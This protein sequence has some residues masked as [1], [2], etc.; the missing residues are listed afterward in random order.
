M[1]RWLRRHIPSMFHRRLVLL[2][3]SAMIVVIILTM[4][5]VSLSVGQAHARRLADAE[6]K[7]RRVE[8]LPTVRGRILDRR[9]R[10]VAMDDAGTEVA[11]GYDVIAGK[12]PRT[13][14]ERAAR[15]Q[16]RAN[17]PE[18][19]AEQR[20]EAI[21]AAQK[22]FEDQL[23]MLWQILADLGG[24]DRL[25]IERRKDRIRQRVQT[26]RSY[27][28]AWRWRQRQAELDEA[29]PFHEVSQPIAEERQAHPI[30]TNAG[31]DVKKRVQAFLAEAE[32]EA[33]AAAEERRQGI[34]IADRMALQPS[35]IWLEVKLRRPKRRLYPFES[36]TIE[37][38]RTHFPGDLKS[39]VP[40]ELTVEGV[41]SHILGRMR[42][43]WKED[44]EGDDGRP[45][46]WSESGR[47][48]DLGGYRDGDHVGASGIERAMEGMPA[49]PGLRGTRGV[50][51]RHLDSDY[52]ERIEPQPGRDV[53][54]TLDIMLQ[55]RIQALMT[56]IPEIG[57]A[58]K[59]PWHSQEPTDPAEL[60]AWHEGLGKPLNGAA[61]VL[62]ART[63]EVLAAVTMPAMPR[64]LLEE[65]PKQIFD[66]VYNLPWVNRTIARPYPPGSTIKPIMLVAAV[67]A[68]AHHL[69]DPIYCWGPLDREKPDQFRCWIFKHYLSQHGPLMGP[70]A[71]ARSC[72]VYFYTLGRSMGLDRTVGWYRRFGLGEPTRVG[73]GVVSEG[74]DEVGGT[75]GN[76]RQ[77]YPADPIFMGIGQGPV[78]WT[79]MQAAGAF[80][81]LAR[82]GVAMS[83]TLIRDEDRLTPRDVT[84]LELNP[85]AVQDALDG[86]DQ[87]ANE[88]FGT[89]HR[90]SLLRE[91]TFNLDGV[92]IMAKSGTADPGKRW[93]DTNHSGRLG[94]EGDTLISS[95]GDHA[96]VVAVVQPDGA[97]RPTHV[98]VVVLEYS[99]SGGNVA[100]PVANQIMHALRQEGYL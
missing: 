47:E 35:R 17:W 69:H 58:I 88:S 100:G 96:W 34:P 86:L 39:E 41:A 37:L 80:A 75:V 84:D 64:G 83:P 92:R 93:I 14:A 97:T 65:D 52:V 66:D 22:P 67:T 31:E 85:A 79:P 3:V 89:T 20:E 56:P 19:T 71:I 24:V 91:P 15:A 49:M 45:F 26:T 98:V 38:D 46:H 60:A 48:T 8:F 82:G 78:S 95:P 59:Q 87:S 81:T 44:M 18:L 16:Y 63:S 90:L 55:A 61:V 30:L 5:A 6:A 13:Q 29:I 1:R 73:L 68:G 76:P 2:G 43:V 42:S 27:V 4:Q 25:E 72:N 94:D 51:I 12:W 74:G 50:A 7:L 10:V 62:D 28:D 77:A 23:E 40:I 9:G 11:V 54:L 36:Q 21:Q 99:G 33:Q 70:E 32:R 53:H 57:L